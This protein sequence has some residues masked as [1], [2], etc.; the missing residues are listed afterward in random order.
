MRLGHRFPK[1]RQ[2]WKMLLRIIINSTDQDRRPPTIREITAQSTV[3]AQSQ[4]YAMLNELH[5]MGYIHM[6]HGKARS[7]V[8][9]ARGI[10]YAYEE[11]EDAT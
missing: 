5:D 8:V 7:F 11:D 6:Q 9:T 3:K 4:V 10:S 2:M 1:T